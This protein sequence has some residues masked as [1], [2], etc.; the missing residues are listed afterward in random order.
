MPDQNK[1]YDLP[2]INYKQR[3]F[4]WELIIKKNVL[5]YDACVQLSKQI[6]TNRT[7]PYG[8]EVPV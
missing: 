4:L 5:L 6:E 8:A 2:I 1:K 7:D 3:H